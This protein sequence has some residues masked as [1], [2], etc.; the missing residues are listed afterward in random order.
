VNAPSLDEVRELSDYLNT[1]FPAPAEDKELTEWV[2]AAA[3]LVSELTGRSIG[4][5]AEGEEVPPFLVPLAKR[6][7][8]LKIEQMV[9]TLGG[10]FAERRA[11]IGAGKLSSF[12]A[13][14]YAETYF[15][16]EIAVSN[17]MLDGDP[18]IADILWALA[19]PEKRE[20]WILKWKGVEA[21]AAMATSFDWSRFNGGY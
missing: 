16:P 21:P 14:A 13:G 6:A 10:T 7:I 20:E 9:T 8:I 1:K 11:S 3:G 18:M 5:G 15:S 4:E 17:G 19:T 12:S 2:A